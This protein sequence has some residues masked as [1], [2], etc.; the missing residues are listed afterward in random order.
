MKTHIDYWLVPV[1]VLVILLRLADDHFNAKRR[2]RRRREREA[3]R[4]EYRRYLRSPSWQGRRQKALAKAA[5]RCRDCGRQMPLQ[6][7]H[8]TYTRVGKEHP[9]D[10]RAICAD[11]HAKRHRRR[12]SPLH[13]LLDWIFN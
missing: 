5:G 13:R 3:R 2:Q 9:K 4:S 8:L 11:C 7:H 10:L 12:Q 1:I 6:V